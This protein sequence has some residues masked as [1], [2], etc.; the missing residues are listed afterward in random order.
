MRNKNQEKE[1]TLIGFN[2]LV[3]YESMGAV[4]IREGAGAEASFYAHQRR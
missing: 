3:E 4:R 1:K 2:L